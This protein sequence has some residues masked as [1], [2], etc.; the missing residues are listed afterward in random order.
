MSP[1]EVQHKITLYLDQIEKLAYEKMAAVDQLSFHL[2]IHRRLGLEVMKIQTFMKLI[3]VFFL[4]CN[5]IPV[6]VA[7]IFLIHMQILAFFVGAEE[8]FVD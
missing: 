4:H 7:G 3:I 2:L 1:A 8:F 6:E 5:H